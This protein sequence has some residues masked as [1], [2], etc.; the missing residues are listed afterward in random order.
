MS[1]TAPNISLASALCGDM[2]ITEKRRAKVNSITG[3]QL[4]HP[5]KAKLIQGFDVD[6]VSA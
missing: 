3:S 5:I 4:V 2:I 6:S 1:T